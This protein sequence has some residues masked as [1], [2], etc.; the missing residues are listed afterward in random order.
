MSVK[1]PFICGDEGNIWLKYVKN[2]K[3]VLHNYVL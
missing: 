1:I 2:G 3:F